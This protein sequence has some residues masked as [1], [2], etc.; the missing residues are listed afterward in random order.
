MIN[1]TKRNTN[2][3]IGPIITPYRHQ[4]RISLWRNLVKTFFSELT[5]LCKKK[6]LL[7]FRMESPTEFCNGKVPSVVSNLQQVI[8]YLM[9]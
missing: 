1:N 3:T 6:C 7:N 4:K 8:L 9:I 5:S 2:P